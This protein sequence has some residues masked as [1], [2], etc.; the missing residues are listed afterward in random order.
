MVN[1][2]KQP[3]YKAINSEDLP[4]RQSSTSFRNP[5]SKF[6]S[7]PSNDRIHLYKAI[8]VDCHHEVQVNFEPAKDKPFYCDYCYVNHRVQHHTDK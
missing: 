4:T 7:I 1:D 6:A 8:C 2:D 3:V 5:S